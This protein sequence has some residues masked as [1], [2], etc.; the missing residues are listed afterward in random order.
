MKKKVCLLTAA[1]AMLL[2]PAY[3]S[4]I[5]GF[6]GVMDTETMGKGNY[7]GGMIEVSTVPFLSIRLSGGYANEFDKVTDIQDRLSNIL[8]LKFD[9]DDVGIVPLEAGLIAD[10]N[11]FGFLGVYAGVGYSYYIIPDIS[12]GIV[13][14]NISY[15][16]DVSDMSGWWA[17]AGVEFG[18][19]IVNLFAEV[20]YADI[21]TKSIDYDITL[22]GHHLKSN[23][24]VDMSNVSVL[25]GIKLKW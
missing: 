11:L 16:Y 4:S 18:L 24:E 25:A 5:G 10:F 17:A 2:A 3:S 7:Y 23:Y 13:G 19:P 1:L 20:R 12:V 9:F 15:D 22:G 8:G 14:T 6:A 21:G